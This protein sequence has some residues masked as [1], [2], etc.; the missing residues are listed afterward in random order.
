[1]EELTLSGTDLYELIG[2]FFTARPGCRLKI[3]CLGYS[4]SPFIKDRNR[5]TIKPLEKDLPLKFGDIVAIAVHDR[6]KILVHRIIKVA[7]PK[8]LIKGD[9]NTG[10]DGWFDK[11]DILGVVENIDMKSGFAYSPKRW[12]SII[13]ALASRFNVF[14]I[15]KYLSSPKMG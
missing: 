4:M 15:R 14:A 12:Q 11:K 7:V 10:A 1:M 3:Q 6:K 8:Y 5:V 9:N 13:I 2:S